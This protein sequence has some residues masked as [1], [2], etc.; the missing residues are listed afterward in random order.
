MIDLKDVI[1][2]HL[3]AGALFLTIRI[4]DRSLARPEATRL[5]S[6]DETTS[7][8]EPT[9]PDDSQ[10]P[11]SPRR[12]RGRPGGGPPRRGL[13]GRRGA[14][15]G[16]A[17]VPYPRP[18]APPRASPAEEERPDEEGYAEARSSGAPTGEEEYAEATAFQRFS[19]LLGIAT[20]A[21]LA[22]ALVLLQAE[23]TLTRN[24]AVPC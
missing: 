14:K 12:R 9:P 16:R 15:A 6:A 1:F 2:F 10:A 13:A 11:A 19:G 4:R 3:T 20:I 22:G 7:P 23:G 5:M 17:G 8:T 24:V 18:P 21:L